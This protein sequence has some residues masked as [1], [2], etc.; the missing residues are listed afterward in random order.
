MTAFESFY[1]TNFNECIVSI[2]S[3]KKRESESIVDTR[4][5]NVWHLQN[6]TSNQR[7]ND[8]KRVLWLSKIIG[9]FIGLE[10]STCQK[11][12]QNTNI[13]LDRFALLLVF[14]VCLLNTNHPPPPPMNNKAIPFG[15]IYRLKQEATKSIKSNVFDDPF[16]PTYAKFVTSFA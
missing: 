12:Q 8:Q 6:D 4:V 9:C 13:P 16:I 14:L 5:A 3:D 15:K 10:S 2:W 11:S 1:S 7:S